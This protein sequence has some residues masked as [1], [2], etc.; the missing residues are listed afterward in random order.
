M[1]AILSVNSYP[2][3]W[4]RRDLPKMRDA[5]LLDA[6]FVRSLDLGTLTVS[7]YESGYD[8]GRLTSMLAERLQSLMVAISEGTLDCLE[9]LVNAGKAEEAMA[10]LQLVSGDW[11]TGRSG[12]HG[13]F[14]S[15]TES[16]VAR[17]SE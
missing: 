3:D 16:P 8:R 17:S 13:F 10:A 1:T 4:V 7:L 11:A 2:M 9:Q 12:T 14:Y 15:L 5:R 6:S